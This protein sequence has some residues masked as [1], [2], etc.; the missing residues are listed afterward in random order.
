MQYLWIFQQPDSS[1]LLKKKWGGGGGKAQ[2]WRK[3]RSVRTPWIEES[4]PTY[5]QPPSP[6]TPQISCVMGYKNYISLV[7]KLL[8]PAKTFKS[9][10]LQNM[11]QMCFLLN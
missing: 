3:F 10:M 2:R 7:C 6:Y 4:M 11:L 5:P 9:K 8:L 1:D